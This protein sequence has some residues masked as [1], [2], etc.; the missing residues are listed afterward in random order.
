MAAAGLRKSGKSKAK[1]SNESW[2]PNSGQVTEDGPRNPALVLASEHEQQPPAC[3]L[4]LPQL[5]SEQ[6]RMQTQSATSLLDQP[7]GGS[8]QHQPTGNN[9]TSLAGDDLNSTA[10]SDA[11]LTPPISR[12]DDTRQDAPRDQDAPI[13]DAPA[14]RFSLRHQ[15]ARSEADAANGA[16]ARS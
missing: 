6:T 5:R 2:S 1:S 16:S 10:I 12:D 15:D 9:P 4:T 8:G 7:Q 14:I 3:Y 13:P 11:Q